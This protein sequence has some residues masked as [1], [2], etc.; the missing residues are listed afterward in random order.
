MITAKYSA[1]RYA[2][3]GGATTYEANS[4]HDLCAQIRI[5]KQKGFQVPFDPDEKI[6]LGDILDDKGK[7]IID[8]L[9]NCN[10][11]KLFRKYNI[12]L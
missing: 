9:Y 10:F 7:K 11:A 1:T 6:R 12:K 3:D 8:E 5:D 4:T 2:N